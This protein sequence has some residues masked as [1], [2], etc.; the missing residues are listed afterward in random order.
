MEKKLGNIVQKI[1]VTIFFITLY[2]PIAVLVIFSFNNQKANRSWEGF[3]FYYYKELFQDTEL[4]EI[5][6]RSLLVAITSTAIAVVI[7]TLAAIVLV[8]HHFRGKELINNL[9]Y[10]PLIVP[11]V[12]TAVA[13]LS[14]FSF[15]GIPRGVIP[16]ILG[17]TT[18]VLPYI[19][20]TVK[21][22]LSGYDPSIEEASMDLG[23]NRFET[24]KNITIPIIMPG[25]MSGALLAFTLSF[26]DLIV[27]DFIG[28][29]SCTTLPI[30]IYSLI[31]LGVSPEINALITVT[32]V[33]AVIIVLVG[34]I[35]NVTKIKKN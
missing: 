28:G 12:V 10:V 26:D 14:S 29:T 20:I 35:I 22:R 15:V 32:I 31:K 4:W 18:L 27:T 9:V 13:L 1:Y 34:K 19:I 30:K 8:R 6:G 24:L 21:S 23:A 17:H 5:M 25:I 2:I 3:T 33:F 11:E 16:V 7:G